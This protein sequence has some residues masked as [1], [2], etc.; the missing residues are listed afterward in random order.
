MTKYQHS[1]DQSSSSIWD[2]HKVIR[3]DFGLLS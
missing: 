2:L 1:L 3:V